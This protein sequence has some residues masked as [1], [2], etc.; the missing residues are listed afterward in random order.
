MRE[1][2]ISEIVKDGEFL[3]YQERAW[4]F[5]YLSSWYSVFPEHIN[6]SPGY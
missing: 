6:L 3:N 5:L 2:L 4:A 1:V